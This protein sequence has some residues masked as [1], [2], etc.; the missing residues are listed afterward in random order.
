MNERE[1]FI[2]GI[3]ANL[4]DDTPRLAFADWLVPHPVWID[5]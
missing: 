4:Y 2:R 1:A 5:G 3:A